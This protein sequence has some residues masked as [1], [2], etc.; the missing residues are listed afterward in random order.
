MIPLLLLAITA[1]AVDANGNAVASGTETNDASLHVIFTFSE[2]VK[3]S[4]FTSADIT[5]INV[6]YLIYFL[7]PVLEMMILSLQQHL[8]Q[9]VMEI[10][11]LK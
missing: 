10:V 6:P 5:V 1:K 3:V 11:A 7:M 4:S 8:H 2:V 9:L